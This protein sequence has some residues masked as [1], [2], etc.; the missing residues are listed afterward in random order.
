MFLQAIVFSMLIP[1]AVAQNV[2]C[3]DLYLTWQKCLVEKNVMPGADYKKETQA[4]AECF[5]TDE[6]FNKLSVELSCDDRTTA[7]CEVFKSCDVCYQSSYGCE[8]EDFDYVVCLSSS[9][10]ESEDDCFVECEFKPTNGGS[11]VSINRKSGGSSNGGSG[12]STNGGSGGSSNGGSD[13]STNGGSGGSSN[14]GSKNGDDKKDTK[15]AGHSY[16]ITAL[17]VVML[18]TLLLA[19]S[20]RQ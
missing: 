6:T 18:P 10:Y 12:G 13:G 11:G 19:S 14:G 9:F 4:C 2:T 3:S 16:E 1:F 17:S 8:Q 7:V 5:H 20:L 15:S